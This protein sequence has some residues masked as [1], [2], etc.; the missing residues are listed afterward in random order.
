MSLVIARRWFGFVNAPPNTI[1]KTHLPS[2]IFLTRIYV[3]KTTLN[4]NMVDS[5]L[6]LYLRCTIIPKWVVAS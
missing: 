5:K 2:N 1:S 6:F 4:S 3:I